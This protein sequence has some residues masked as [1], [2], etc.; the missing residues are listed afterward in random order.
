MLRYHLFTAASYWEPNYGSSDVKQDFDFL[1]HFSPVHNV[2]PVAYPAMIVS[3][4]Y[5]DDRVVPAHAYKLAATLQERATAKSGP[6][7]MQV[8]KNA[9]HNS[10]GTN[11]L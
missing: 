7:Y 3:T 4:A 11:L 9:D 2:K 5:Q 10:G 8:T 1:L 6:I